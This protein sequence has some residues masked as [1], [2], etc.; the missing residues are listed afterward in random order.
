MPRTQTARRG[1]RIQALNY[2]ILTRFIRFGQ[3]LSAVCRFLATV[4]VDRAQDLSSPF[5]RRISRRKLAETC[6]AV[7]ELCEQLGIDA[8]SCHR[9]AATHD[10]LRRNDRHIDGTVVTMVPMK[11]P[12][13]VPAPTAAKA[14]GSSAAAPSPSRLLCAASGA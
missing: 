2:F 8:T 11:N 9:S 14:G 1:I 10:G 5:A 12:G 6:Q 4:R 7:H 13:G 3:L